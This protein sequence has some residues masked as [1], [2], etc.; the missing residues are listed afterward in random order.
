MLGCCLCRRRSCRLRSQWTAIKILNRNP[1]AEIWWWPEYTRF[2]HCNT[3]W[4]GSRCSNCI[5]HMNA[6]IN[7]IYKLIR[8]DEKNANWKIDCSLQVLWTTAEEIICMG[9]QNNNRNKSDQQNGKK[10]DE[11]KT[12][13]KSATNVMQQQAKGIIVRWNSE[14]RKLQWKQR[15]RNSFDYKKK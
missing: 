11:E 3:V 15:A 10:S 14:C 13:W 7:K 1:L 9:F 4:M 8:L 2:L 5:M 6:P 12:D